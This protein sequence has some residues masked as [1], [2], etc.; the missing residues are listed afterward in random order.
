MS[1]GD[2]SS[3]ATVSQVRACLD[4][5]YRMLDA[6]KAMRV[7]LAAEGASLRERISAA[8]IQQDIEEAIRKAHRWL[9]RRA[10]AGAG[11]NPAIKAH[12]CAASA[13]AIGLALRAGQDGAATP[14]ADPLF[15]CPSEQ[16]LPVVAAAGKTQSR[17]GGGG[18]HAIA[19]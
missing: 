8:G 9:A 7:D 12:G 6:C 16:D 11:W 10:R 15:S 3:A 18:D 13:P 2:F 1:L 14:N 4:A 5:Y 19:N 17:V